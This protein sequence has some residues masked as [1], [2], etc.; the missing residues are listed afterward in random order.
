MSKLDL[1]CSMKTL[2]GK[3][4]ADSGLILIAQVGLC[5]LVEIHLVS[6]FKIQRGSKSEDVKNV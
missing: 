4:E 2:S 1:N 3:G 6:K 5:L